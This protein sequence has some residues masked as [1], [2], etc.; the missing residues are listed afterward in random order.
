MTLL[1]V[2]YFSKKFLYLV[3]HFL[4]GLTYLTRDRVFFLFIM[5]ERLLLLEDMSSKDLISTSCVVLVS[6][7][8]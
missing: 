4:D 3:S 6:Q 7:A 8:S 2:D 1:T 5:M